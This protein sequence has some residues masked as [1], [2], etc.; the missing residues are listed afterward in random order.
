MPRRIIAVAL[1]WLVAE[2]RLRAEGQAG[3]ATPFAVAGQVGGALRLIGVNRTGAAAGLSPG[4]ALSDARAICP[5]VLTRTDVPE[6]RAVFLAALTRWAERFSPLVGRDQ[7]DALILDATGAAHLFG[8]EAAMLAAL[9][10]ALADHGLSARAAMADTK[11]AAWALAHY[12]GDD[13]PVIVPPGRTRQ[14]IGALPTAALRLEPDTTETLAKVGL[15]T[16][17]PLTRMPRGGLARRF[18]LDAMRRLDQALGADTGEKR[19]LP[20][21]VMVHLHEG[22]A[23]VG[24]DGVHQLLHPR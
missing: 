2:H 17:E 13:A 23:A 3:L 6:R 14:A 15:T 16:I 4:M 20:G 24:V 1:P 19:V 21:A 5:G 8:G 7:A 11:G 9:T 12:G 10:E 18:G 22:G